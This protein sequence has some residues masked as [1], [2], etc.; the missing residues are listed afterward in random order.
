MS[1]DSARTDGSGARGQREC[2]SRHQRGRG[3]EGRGGAARGDAMAM[4]MAMAMGRRD[5]R[6]SRANAT[7]RW[8]GGRFVDGLAIAASM[9]DA[10]I[11]G[12]DWRM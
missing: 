6:R 8:T 4:A 10:A 12:V 5:R 3:R 1:P 9:G 7:A 11:A 2:G